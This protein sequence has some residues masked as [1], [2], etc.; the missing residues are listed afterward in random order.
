MTGTSA[1]CQILVLN[2]YGITDRSRVE[3]VSDCHASA[4]RK[5]HSGRQQTDQCSASTS[6]LT[7]AWFVS[8]HLCIQVVHALNLEQSVRPFTLIFGAWIPEHDPFTAR[9]LNQREQPANMIP[10][11]DRDLPHLN[12]RPGRIG[13]REPLF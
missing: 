3:S 7:S 13:N 2:D 10:V 11:F 12:N 6:M 8:N 5:L 9:I 1:R 4:D